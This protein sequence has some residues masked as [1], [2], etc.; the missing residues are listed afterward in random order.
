MYCN[1][2]EHILP[3][4]WDN[5]RNPEN[6]KTARDAEY[7]NTGAGASV[8]N[9]V[10]WSRQLTDTEAVKYTLTNFFTR[11]DTWTIDN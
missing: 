11:K 8:E 3:T 6:E 9:R 7:K 1:L 10:T 2:G 5:W 4:G